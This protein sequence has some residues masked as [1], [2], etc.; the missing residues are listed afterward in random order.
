LF[1]CVIKNILP[2]KTP[3]WLKMLTPFI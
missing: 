1:Y 2:K 3:F